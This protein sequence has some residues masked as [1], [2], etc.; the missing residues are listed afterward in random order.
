MRTIMEERF[1]HSGNA[2]RI[3]KVRY[4]GKEGKTPDGCPIAKWVC[5]FDSFV[6]CEM[7]SKLFCCSK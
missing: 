6:E 1:G 4:T 2:V 7:K 5:T 3:E